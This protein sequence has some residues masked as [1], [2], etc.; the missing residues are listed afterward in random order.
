MRY[1]CKVTTLQVA[2]VEHVATPDA[3][4]ALRR[5][6]ARALAARP[7]FQTDRHNA[8]LVGFMSASMAERAAF[9]DVVV[10]SLQAL[11]ALELP[12]V[13]Q[14]PSLDVDVVSPEDAVRRLMVRVF[15][16]AA[17][18]AASGKPGPVAP[19]PL[20]K[21]GNRLFEPTPASC[22]PLWDGPDA[23][24]GAAFALLAAAFASTLELR[25]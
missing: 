2:S 24:Y 9:A 6:I 14:D 13:P 11:A 17:S 22:E 16:D 21:I 10:E 4:D 23:D 8:M 1:S 20:W 18:A 19:H 5:A 3:R 12:H 7:V 25:S 15:S